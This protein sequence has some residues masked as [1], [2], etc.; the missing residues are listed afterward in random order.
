M[1]AEA[2]AARCEL[3]VHREAVG[4]RQRGLYAQ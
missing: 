2:L 1:R 3:L 4:F